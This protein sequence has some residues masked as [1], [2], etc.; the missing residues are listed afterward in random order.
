VARK[1]GAIAMV[2]QGGLLYVLERNTLGCFRQQPEEWVWRK[3]CDLA[4][5]FILAGDKIIA[6]GADKLMAF[7]RSDGTAVWQTKVQGR[8]QGLAVADKTLL[9]STDEGLIYA[10]SE[11]SDANRAAEAAPQPIEYRPIVSPLSEP[12]ATTAVPPEITLGP[13]IRFPTRGDAV[14]TWTT[15]AP[16]PTTLVHGSD[17]NI[18]RYHSPQPVTEHTVRLSSLKH[19]TVYRWSLVLDDGAEGRVVGPFECDTHLNMSPPPIRY[20]PADKSQ[21]S[22]IKPPN[23]ELVP[24]L[25][26]GDRGV[27]LIV[28]ADAAQWSMATGMRTIIMDGGAAQIERLRTMLQADGL[29]GTRIDVIEVVDFQR[30]PI[31]DHIANLVVVSPALAQRLGSDWVKSLLHKAVP[32]SGKLLLADQPLTSVLTAPAL[33][34]TGDWSHQYGRPD[35]ATF[36]DET[37]QGACHTS[38]FRV[39]WLGR[40]GPRFQSDRGNRKPAPLFAGGRLLVQGLDRLMALDAYNG[41]VL[42]NMEVPDSRR[43]N[44]RND[45]ANWCVDDDHVY[46]AVRNGCW[47]I[48]AATGEVQQAF[49]ADDNANNHWGYVGRL[50]RRLVGTSV[51][52]GSAFQEFWGGQYWYTDSAGPLAA[53]VCSRRLFAYDLVTNQ[54]AWEY[55]GGTIIHTSITLDDNRVLFVECRDPEIAKLNGGRIES[56]QLWNDLQLVALSLTD[57]RELWRQ[58]LDVG[59]ATTMFS[60]A[61]GNGH[62]VAV[63]SRK[64]DYHV[65]VRELATGKPLWQTVFDWEAN[66]KGGDSARP[67]IID[68]TLY[69]S[70]RA[71]DLATGKEL[72]QKLTRGACGSYAAAKN[73]FITRLGNLGLWDPQAGQAS[74]WQKLRP[75]CWLSAIPAGGLILAPEGGGGCSCGGW[76][77]TSITFSPKPAK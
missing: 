49:S 37:L 28:G 20:R 46:F 25:R 23:L 77:E 73:V 15:A 38:D 16:Q 21:A 27:C 7:R 39:Q 66:G 45:S 56:A 72:P 18:T 60:L 14:I 36:A 44:I 65:E 32:K 33:A 50:G 63:A 22:T 69:V 19:N 64:S 30:L 75:D 34:E 2:A 41:T 1:F 5:S 8:V 9:V 74:G 12:L 57:G 48:D 13:I 67:V 58:P 26:H 42:W 53:K 6:G 31:T 59:A 70:P 24:K 71:F 43:F 29:L 3:P 17:G 10:L 40:P 35:N 68:H 54:R 47:Q 62:I 76:I 61:S 52:P 11:I 55:T 51:P 4:D